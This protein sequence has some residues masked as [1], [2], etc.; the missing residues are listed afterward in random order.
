MSHAGD[1]P[2]NSGIIDIPATDDRRL[3]VLPTKMEAAAHYSMGSGA[4]RRRKGLE[5]L[6][7]EIR[8]GAS[9]FETPACGCEHRAGDAS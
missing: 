6:F 8:S 4:G 1:S 3:I 5:S 9:W 2:D 7:E